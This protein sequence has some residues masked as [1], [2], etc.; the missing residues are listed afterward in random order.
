MNVPL[1]I[2]PLSTI[3]KL[4]YKFPWFGRKLDGMFPTLRV[5]LLM[6]QIPMTMEEFAISALVSSALISFFITI[7]L[8][9]TSIILKIPKNEA[10]VLTLGPAV[11]IFFLYF[12]VTLFY[13]QILS[14]KIAEQIDKDLI[15]ALKDLLLEVS[16]GSS[17]YNAMAGVV[18]SNYG[19]VSKEFEKVLKRTN[20]GMPLEDSLEQLAVETPSTHLRNACWQI[21]N[22]LK[23]GTMLTTTLRGIVQDLTSD[24]HRK[25]KS[26]AQELNV[27]ALIYLLFAV[28]IP[29]IVTTLAIVMASFSG[30]QVSEDTFLYI[31][32]VC[33]FIQLVLV[34]LI[35]SRRPTVHL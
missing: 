14:K 9:L 22:S 31:V 16:A 3:K 30:A 15:F 23:A 4:G 12:I 29:T 2:I 27:L 21:L 24:Q 19:L 34:G 33:Y 32:V 6:A 8:F 7:G 20:R 35:R 13:P 5:H 28:A 25:I 17:L 11:L 1:I 26:Y 18:L 10:I